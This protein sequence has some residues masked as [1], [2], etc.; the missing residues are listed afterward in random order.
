MNYE[1]ASVTHQGKVRK[2][3]QDRL[4]VQQNGARALLAVAD[5]MG[6]LACG[7]QASG[8]I[9]STLAQR[10]NK[11]CT[12]DN[13]EEAARR[14]DEAIFEAHRRVFYFS[15]ELQK[16]VGSTLS[17]LLLWEDVYRIKQ[18]GDS[19]VYCL[20]AD[21]LEQ[22]TIDQNWYNQMVRTGRLSPAEAGRNP[23]RRALVNAVGASAELEVVTESGVLKAGMCF[24]LCTDGLYASVDSSFLTR[25]LA[26]AP[27]QA[28]DVLLQETLCGPAGDNATAIC[29]RVR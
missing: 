15:E 5:G 19:R 25:A 24:L 16:P 7:E 11:I 1:V 3:N 22:L 4:L 21:G 9:I 10:W 17:A 29:C 27:A 23:Q 20:D 14:L 28:L 6:G 2:S 8:Q 18:I 12:A 13:V 26:A